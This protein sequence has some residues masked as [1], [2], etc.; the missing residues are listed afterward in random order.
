MATKGGDG[1]DCAIGVH[2]DNARLNGADHVMSSG[3]IAGE[4]TWG[5]TK[6]SVIGYSHG[7]CFIFEA[8]HGQHRAGKFITQ[9][10][11][12]GRAIAIKDC[13]RKVETW[14]I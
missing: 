7:L 10:D 8:D 4:H 12:I 11:R 6:L 3:Q 2:P 9:A 14:K 13:W 1:A 5:Q